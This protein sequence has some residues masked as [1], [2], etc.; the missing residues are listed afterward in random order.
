M[1]FNSFS[2]LVF[3]PIVAALF[4]LTP[5]RYRTVLLL[6][7]SYVFYMSFIPEYGI[8]ILGLTAF[9]Y[10]MG[11]LIARSDSLRKHIL[12]ASVAGNLILLAY[13]K[14]TFFC[15]H[16]INQ[17]LLKSG[18]SALPA[19]FQILLPLG[20][21]FFVFEFIH[22][23]VDIYKGSAPVKKPLE[24]ALFA[25][26]FPT[27]I[28]GPI[29]RYQDFIPQLHVPQ[30]LDLKSFD[31]GVELILFGLFKKVLIA[32]NLA[33][34]VQTA[35]ANPMSF[36]TADL[37]L[38]AY[39]FSFQVYFD[40]SGY[41]D[42]ARGSA[43]LLGFT[44]PKNFNVPYVASS[45]ADYWRRW[46][47]S[48][49]TWLRD[50][51]FFPLGGSKCSRWLVARNLI[52]TMTL[53]GLWHGAGYNYIVFGAIHGVLLVIHREWRRLVEKFAGVNRFVSTPVFHV[54][55]I[56][57]TFHTVVVSEV[58][59]RAEKVSTGLSIIKRL[60]LIDVAQGVEPWQLKLVST[61]GPAIYICLPFVIAI[62][63]F[64]QLLA[65]KFRKAGTPGILPL[66]HWLNPLRPAYLAAIVCLLI[67]FAPDINPRFIYFQF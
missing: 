16:I 66:P 62:L 12:I 7:A 52:I 25:S 11:L 46:H 39:S 18:H 67:V 58:I 2:Y 28:A 61:D 26:F 32:D 41:T 63:F 10:I 19:H 17:A 21:S 4:W 55:A 50:Y 23:L 22:Y 14:Y 49:S 31:E 27:Q 1:L 35:F 5:F 3:L 30:K 36:T 6:I 60:F 43:Q 37:W 8:L 45:I 54:L 20:I 42:I 13:F 9:N 57:L 48:L 56:F 33:L 65:A 24:F 64:G 34:I 38:A 44:V 40:F 15:L 53:C 29:K 59:F 47:I 51:L